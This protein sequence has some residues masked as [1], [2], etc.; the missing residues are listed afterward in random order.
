MSKYTCERV[1]TFNLEGQFLEFVLKDS[2][3]IKYMRVAT[4]EGESWIELSKQARASLL[5]HALIPGDWIQV[6]GQ[7]KYK[8]ASDKLKLK[9]DRVTPAARSDAARLAPVK[10]KPA[11]VKA[12]VLVCQ[13]SDCRKRGGDRLCQAL[14]ATLRSRGLEEYVEIQKTG[15]LKKCKAGPNVVVM[16]DKTCYSRIS[17]TE[18]PAL[19]DKHFS[20][21]T[22]R[23]DRLPQSSPA[24]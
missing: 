19:I 5:G 7:K 20:S 21:A 18:M 6:C 10:A 16:P 1:S 17:P 14:E 4:S 12:R 22:S 3:K 11:K 13:K 9:A 23:G 8:S 2:Y 24:T 15:C